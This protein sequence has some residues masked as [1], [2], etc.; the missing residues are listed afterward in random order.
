MSLVV[1]VAF[2][3]GIRRR[4]LVVVVMSLVMPF[5]TP[6]F[7]RKAILRSFGTLWS[8]LRFLRFLRSLRPLWSFLRF[9]RSLRPFGTLGS[10]GS[11]GILRSF[12]RS[13]VRMVVESTAQVPD[14]LAMYKI[15]SKPEQ[16]YQGV[17]VLHG[18]VCE[19]CFRQKSISEF[20]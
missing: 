18:V 16:Y 19:S 12:R 10:L 11:L 13:L 3:A 14:L 2:G 15:R 5:G 17:P 4:M 8:F 9:L 6:R 7:G 20:M 1:V